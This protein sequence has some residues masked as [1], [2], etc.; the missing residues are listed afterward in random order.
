MEHSREIAPV[1]YLKST[2]RPIEAFQFVRKLM[3]SCGGVL[4][5]SSSGRSLVPGRR[6]TI[7]DPPGE[8]AQL[9]VLEVGR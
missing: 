5:I 7:F 1:S 2:S 9:L 3:V 6:Y 8:D 4:L